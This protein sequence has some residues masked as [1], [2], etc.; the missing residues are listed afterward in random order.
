MLTFVRWIITAGFTTVTVLI[1]SRLLSGNH[2]LPSR[3]PMW[4][5]ALIIAVAWASFYALTASIHFSEQTRIAWSQGIQ[6]LTLGHVGV[7]LV[8]NRGR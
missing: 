2:L 8:M 7:V 6:L 3:R 5:S 1:A 4:Y